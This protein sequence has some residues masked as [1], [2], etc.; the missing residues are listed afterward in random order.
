MNPMN[1]A[2]LNGC[3]VILQVEMR[4]GIP[5]KYLI[6][7]YM[8][9]GHCI[10]DHPPIEAGW[11]FWNGL[12]FDKAAEPIGWMPIPGEE[13]NFPI[14]SMVGVR[15]TVSYNNQEKRWECKRA[16]R[17][18]FIGWGDSPRTAYINWYNGNKNEPK[19]TEF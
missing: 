3:E 10:E 15:P 18:D 19:S 11:Y 5:G 4:A 7:H 2:P 14:L 12:M 6:G 13:G 17:P 8:R 16:D 1:T 9:G